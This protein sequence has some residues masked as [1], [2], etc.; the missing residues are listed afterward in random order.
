[1]LRLIYGGTFDPVHDGH[2]AVATAAAAALAPCVLHLLPSADPP[3]RARPGASAA[4]RVDM[5][6]LAFAAQP[7]FLIDQRELRR[8]G[9]SFMVDTLLDLRREYGEEEPLALLL[10]AD[11]FLGLPSW[12]RWRQLLDLCHLVVVQRPGHRLD[13]LPPELAEEFDSRVATSADELR[14]CAAGRWLLLDLPLRPESATRARQAMHGNAPDTAGVD[15][16]VARYIA[17]HRLYRASPAG[18]D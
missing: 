18:V 11:A 4:Q 14:H 13:A 8:D 2:V 1:M 16:A 17:D 6:R 15:P 12:S 10:G 3:H 7:E 9:P 5:L